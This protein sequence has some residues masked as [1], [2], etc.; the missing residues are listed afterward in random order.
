MELLVLGALA[1]AGSLRSKRSAPKP[2]AFVPHEIENDMT[3]DEVNKNMQQTVANHMSDE[4]TVTSTNQ[5]P[6]FKSQRSQNTNDAVKDRRLATFTGVDMIEFDHKHEVEAP[7][8]TRD[9]TNVY[10]STFSPDIDRYKTYV[11]NSTHNNTSLTP[12]QLVGPGLGL[13]PGEAAEGGFHQFY[14]IKPGNVNGYRKHNHEGRIVHG[15]NA[16]DNRS[17][18]MS[19]LTNSSRALTEPPAS[20]R[21]LDSKQS[22]VP[23]HMI[24]SPS[25]LGCTNRNTASSSDGVSTGA[26]ATY[27]TT[28][29]T[30]ERSSMVPTNTFGNPHG[31][32]IGAYSDR[33]Y[34]MHSTERDTLNVQA[35]NV[36][37]GSGG[38][39][40][41]PSVD[42]HTL[43]EQ[44]ALG[45]TNATPV[46]LNAPSINRAGYEAKPTLRYIPTDDYHGNPVQSNG[47]GYVQ[48]TDH[49]RP[50]LR[51]AEARVMHG[52]ANGG[53]YGTTPYS[54]V[55]N[56]TQCYDKKEH[57]VVQHTPNA[58]TFNVVSDPNSFTAHYKDDNRSA[59][60][61][62]PTAVY[63]PNQTD[64][65]IPSIATNSKTDVMNT[66]DF[67]YAQTLLKDNPFAIDIT[68]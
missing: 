53:S 8:P 55:Y 50:T 33:T 46:S 4:Y 28:I 26:P 29:A 42:S 18:S 67:G 19:A 7:P 16:I 65:T 48:S 34:H 17:E 5:L 9:L 27:S 44:T 66:R 10:G 15:K 3:I 56:G 13:K 23:A 41:T 39:Y 24:H 43:R 63:D 21:G 58:N 45:I 40:T 54:Q 30:R 59:S 51:D 35:T 38:T 36:S 64:R 32:T 61:T 60:H 22:T 20:Y 12:S 14:R 31:Q 62:N 52:P 2:E 6:F 47:G 11:E 37:M 1:Y 57:T 49:T 68:A 25:I